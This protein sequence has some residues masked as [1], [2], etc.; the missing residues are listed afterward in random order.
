MEFERNFTCQISFNSKTDTEGG[1]RDYVL[2]YLAPCP[3]SD[4]LDLPALVPAT[5]PIGAVF[6]RI[7]NVPSLQFT[8]T[9]VDDPD[10]G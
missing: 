4:I 3:V 7:T 2:S 6:H 10:H 9:R 8:T 5:L 1:S